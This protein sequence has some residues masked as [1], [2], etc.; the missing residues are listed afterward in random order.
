[1]AKGSGRSVQE[2]NRLLKRYESGKEMAKKL[3]GMGSG[4]KFF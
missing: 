3:K 4:G 1:M 2:I